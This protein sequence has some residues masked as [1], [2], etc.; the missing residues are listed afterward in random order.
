MMTMMTYWKIDGKAYGPTL[1]PCADNAKLREHICNLMKITSLPKSFK[2]MPFRRIHWRGHPCGR[3]YEQNT[4]T[5]I[6][7]LSEFPHTIKIDNTTI[8]PKFG[9]PIRCAVSCSFICIPNQCGGYPTFD[10][11]IPKGREAFRN[12]ITKRCEERA[13]RAKRNKR[14]EA[15]KTHIGDFNGDNENVVQSASFFV[16]LDQTITEADVSVVGTVK[17]FSKRSI[18]CQ[19]DLENHKIL[20]TNGQKEIEAQNIDAVID[21]AYGCLAGR[22]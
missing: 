6:Q 4:K 12:N 16:Y 15:A 17:F 1:Q 11:G 22:K 20:T 21:A 2:I 8:Y 10:V 14:V 18:S 9:L 3:L 5:L 19:F 13:A 7:A